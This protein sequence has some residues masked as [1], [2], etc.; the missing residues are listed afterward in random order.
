MQTIVEMISR[1]PA[2]TWASFLFLMSGL[3]LGCGSSSTLSSH[4]GATD[5]V[6]AD[7]TEADATGGI[8]DGPGGSDGEGGLPACAWPSALDDPDA[9]RGSCHPARF[10]L[11]CGSQSGVSEECLSDDPDHCAGPE[12]GPGLAFTCH[13]ICGPH[14]YGAA[15]GSIGPGPIS[16]PPAGCH[17]AAPT[18]G[19]VVFYCCPCLP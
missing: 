7:S 19:G 4:D 15:C 8:G 1:R 2:A 5:N 13:D 14:E 16:D 12:P 9:G 10:Y 11:G 18:P 3:A 17:G 6:A